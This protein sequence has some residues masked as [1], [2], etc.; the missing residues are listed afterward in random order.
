MTPFEPPNAVLEWESAGWVSRW[1]GKHVGRVTTPGV[2]EAY[3]E[4]KGPFFYGVGGMRIIAEV[5][6]A[7][8]G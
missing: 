4:A 2:F 8:D 1:S 5:G 3:G 7:A 6:R